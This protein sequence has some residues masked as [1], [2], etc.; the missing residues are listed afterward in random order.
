MQEDIHDRHQRLTAAAMSEMNDIA[1]AASSASRHGRPLDLDLD[2]RSAAEL[3]QHAAQRLAALGEMTGGIAHDFRNILAAIESGLRLAERNAG[4][5]DKVRE[6][7]AGARE[8][9]ARGLKLTSQLLTF[10]R[11]HELATRAGDINLLLRQLEL[12]LKYAAGPKLRLVMELS[13]DLPKCLIDESQFNA[14]ILNL[15]VN[16]RDAMPE[17]GDVLIGT[18]RYVA[19]SGHVGVHPQTC[20]RVRVKDNGRGMAPETLARIFDPFFTTKGDQGTGLGL[21]QVCAFMRLIGGRVDVTSSPGA[22]T[23]FDLVLQAADANP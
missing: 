1:T 10:A 22:G 4:A 18:D 11:Q 6:F 2:E 16:A 3:R 20:V 17:G 5:P 7:I 21:P 23:T 19:P 13:P 14:A 12:F 15:V 9:V 8:G